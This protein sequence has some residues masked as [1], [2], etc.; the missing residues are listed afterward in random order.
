[1]LRLS[2]ITIVLF[3]FLPHVGM[4]QE[5]YLKLENRRGKTVRAYRVGD[6]IEYRKKEGEWKMDQITY[7]D[8]ESGYLGL[9]NELINL[10][11]IDKIRYET[12][13]FVQT[14]KYALYAAAA[15]VTLGATMAVVNEKDDPKS[16]LYGIPFLAAGMLVPKKWYRVIKL[17]EKYVLKVVDLKNGLLVN[18]AS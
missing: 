15:G 10:A 8:A 17:R 2:I 6:L 11:D 16:L 1:M 7:F 18:P 5:A 3:F 9:S 14:L 4:S 12:S 13:G